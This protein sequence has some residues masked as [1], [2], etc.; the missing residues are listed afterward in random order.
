MCLIRFAVVFL[1]SYESG[2]IDV[3][4]AATYINILLTF[5]APFEIISIYIL[6]FK[7]N[8]DCS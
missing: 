6:R 4:L 1:Q 3:S 2:R 8:C 7:V 5:C